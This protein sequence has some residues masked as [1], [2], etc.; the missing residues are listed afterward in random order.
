MRVA[1]DAPIDPGRIALSRV[2]L[3]AAL[4]VYGSVTRVGLD[5]VLNVPGGGA[6]G[7]A[8]HSP[9]KPLRSFSASDPAALMRAVRDAK[10]LD[11]GGV[12]RIDGEHRLVDRLPADTTTSS[13]EALMYFSRGQRFI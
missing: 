8:P 13:W 9:T 1:D 4:S 7:R 10:P 11:T 6:R 3:N 2:G 5:Y 12:R